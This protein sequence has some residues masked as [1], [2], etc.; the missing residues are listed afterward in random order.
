MKR[1]NGLILCAVIAGLLTGGML[2][3]CEKTL[4]DTQ[5]VTDEVCEGEGQVTLRFTMYDQEDFTTYDQE[6]FGAPG[7]AA[8]SRAATDITKICTRLNIA[9]FSTDGAKVKSV[10]QK[11][12]DASYGSVTMT[13]PEGSYRLVVIA[14]N[15]DGSATITSE[16]KVTFPNNKMTDTFYYDGALTVTADQQ[17]RDL[18][19]TR[20]VAMVRMVLTDTS[21]PANVAKFKFYYL[22]GSSTFSPLAGYGCV[23]SKQTEVR[24]VCSDGTYELYTLPHQE[25]DVLTKLTVTA[26][27]A[28]DNAIVERTFENIPITR[29]K[30]TRFKG[31]FFGEGGTEG[32]TSE[33]A[34]RFLADPEWDGQEEQSF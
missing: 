33:G 7:R 11:E 17:T 30:V 23:Q 29:N 26:L 3:G 18:T 32:R 1:E 16:D 27:D 9:V 25:D 6:D 20:A 14:H 22:G 5:G 8:T 2:T 19:L 24:T 34:M 15:G 28:Q 10:A 13:L 31:A 4:L 12:G 21:V